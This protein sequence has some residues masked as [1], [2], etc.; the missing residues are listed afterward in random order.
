VPELP[1]VETIRRQLAPIVVGRIVVSAWSHPSAKF[2][3]ATEVVGAEIERIDRRGKFLLFGLDDDREM[4]VHLGMTGQLLPGDAVA[5]DDPYL[6]A[7]WTFD[8]GS[9]LGYRDV[10]RFG[11]IRVVRRGHY[12]GTLASLGPEPFSDQFTA[13]HLQRAVRASNRYVKTQLLSQRPVA[14]V[15]NI[16]ADEAC[17][18]A[19]VHPAARTPTRRQAAALHAA[20]VEVLRQGVDNG[21]TT[22]RDYVDADGAA[23]ANQH[24]LRCYGRGGEPCERCGEP[25][26]SAVLDARTTT[27]CAVCQPRRW[28]ADH[29]QRLLGAPTPPES[30]TVSD[31]AAGD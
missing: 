18:L 26:R 14:G 20:L 13:A 17:W 11:R 25:L 31:T 19:G 7:R 3:P 16:Y 5:A 9:A 21:G 22:L 2:V 15:G 12:E 1:E 29:E 8:D 6:R 10:R 23:G 24:H 4:V 27:W 30:D 28:P